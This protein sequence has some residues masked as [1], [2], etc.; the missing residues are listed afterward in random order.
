MTHATVPV[1]ERDRLGHPGQGGR[2]TEGRERAEVEEL[3]RGRERRVAP[4]GDEENLALETA[5]TGALPRVRQ[6]ARQAR[7]LAGALNED[8]D[9]LSRE[10]VVL[11]R[12]ARAEDAPILGRVVAR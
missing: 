7:E 8:R 4:A 11:H 12:Q 2:R 5:R 3:R 10:R 9:R 6:G 1:G